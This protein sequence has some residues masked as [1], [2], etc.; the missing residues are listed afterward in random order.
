MRS[1]IL[2]DAC[3]LSKRASAILC[4]PG[5][6]TVGYPEPLDVAADSNDFT[7]E[8]VA[9]HERKSWPQDRATSLAGT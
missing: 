7:R 8:F 5:K 9:E 6:Q 2:L 4:D 3:L 1:A